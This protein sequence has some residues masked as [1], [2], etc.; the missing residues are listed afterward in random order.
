[1]KDLLVLVS[2]K[3]DVFVSYLGTNPAIFTAPTPNARDVN[4]EETD[5]EFAALTNRIKAVQDQG[6]TSVFLW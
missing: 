6:E 4:Y 2:R 1:M 3:G 5:V